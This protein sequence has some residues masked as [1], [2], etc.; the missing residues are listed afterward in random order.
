[1]RTAT[2]LGLAGSLLFAAISV[3]WGWEPL[4]Q[5][6]RTSTQTEQ[7]SQ[8]SVPTR[9]PRPL[10][11]G[12]QGTQQSEIKFKPVTR[13]VTIK[14]HVEDPNGYFLPNL[15]RDNFVVYEDG[16]RQKNVSA[17]V[18]HAP[19]S[20]ALLMEAGGRYH[21][22]NQALAPEMDEAGRQLLNVLGRD[23]E[24][25]VFKYGDHL[26]T[27]VDFNQGH[28]LLDQ[29]FERHGTPSFSEAN[30]YD[31]LLETLNRA[32]AADGDRKAVI[33][34]SDGLDTFS[35]ASR[36][37][38]LQSARQGGIP[39]Y[40]IGLVRI[41]Q[42]ET[43]V[44]GT[45]APFARINWNDAGKFLEDLAKVS[46]GRAYVLETETTV[47]A[48][49]D[50]I[51]ENLRLRFVVTYVSSNPATSGPPRQIRVELVDPK[52]GQVLKI[53]D[54]NGKAIAAKVFVQESYRPNDAVGG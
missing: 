39:I 30:L 10:F 33:V 40:S 43:A 15:R 47:A 21:E 3:T 20:I 8:V 7:S 41:I 36:D 25:A 44:Y 24:V 49:Y 42:R 6:T 22:L 13:Q 12:E 37:Q 18:E 54:S 27:L 23:D 38:V 29:A 45:T 11:K 4:R 2:K 48:I 46:G 53:H 28:E 14:F 51:M 34:I 5:Q 17:E 16:V 9:P 1:M 26:E 32:R 52:T 31:A 50:D 19:V 35:K